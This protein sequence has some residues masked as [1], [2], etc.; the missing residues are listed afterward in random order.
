MT[1]MTHP[2]AK[3]LGQ[4]MKPERK[5]DKVYGDYLYDNGDAAVW[6]EREEQFGQ[7]VKCVRYW[8]VARGAVRVEQGYTSATIGRAV[9]LD[10][11]ILHAVRA[12]CA[13][14]WYAPTL[15]RASDNTRRL[16]L[17]HGSLT[18][19]FA[20]GTDAGFHE[21]PGTVSMG[22]SFNPDLRGGFGGGGRVHDPIALDIPAPETAPA[23]EEGGHV[24]Q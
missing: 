11:G 13:V 3:A 22:V 4:I 1:T 15:E 9:L 10:P 19:H 7:S 6:F 16:G 12:G 21:M 17:P 18:V 24:T 8:K 23:V 5:G 14:S 2:N 20:D